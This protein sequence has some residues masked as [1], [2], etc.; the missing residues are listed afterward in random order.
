MGT[1]NHHR[2]KQSRMN[3]DLL[4]KTYSLDQISP[5][6]MNERR[7]TH[8]SNQS[9][10]SLIEN[11]Q[12]DHPSQFYQEISPESPQMSHRVSEL[13]PEVTWREK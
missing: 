2:E 6:L 4:N 7:S 9:R 1:L 12:K 13:L 8:K 10:F 11:A 5:R 3:Q